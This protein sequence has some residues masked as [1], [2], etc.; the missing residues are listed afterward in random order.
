M[1]EPAAAPGGRF[2]TALAIGRPAG[3]QVIGVFGL[4]QVF[5]M[6]CLALHRGAGEVAD[7][8]AGMAPEAGDGGV[9]AGEWE[10]GPIVL[11]DLPFGDPI[12]LGVAGIAALAE[13]AA[14]DVLMAAGAAALRERPD[15]SAIVVAPQALGLRVTRQIRAGG[16][17]CWSQS[18]GS[19]LVAT[20]SNPL[21]LPDKLARVIFV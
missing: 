6:A 21:H 9:G 7:L 1:I 18:L 10:A 8:G 19:G 3:G 12:S 20:R 17:V 16:L 4:L 14:V 15:G 2:V 13:L 11:G 5:L